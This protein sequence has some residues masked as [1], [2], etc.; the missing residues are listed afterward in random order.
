MLFGGSSR[1]KSSSLALQPF[2]LKL[3]DAFLVG[4]AGDPRESSPCVG[5]IQKWLDDRKVWNEAGSMSDLTVRKDLVVEVMEK[6]DPH[7][8]Y[9]ISKDGTAVRL[10]CVVFPHAKCNC[11]RDRYIPAKKIGEHTNFTF[12]PILQLRSARYGT[13]EGNI[14]MSVAAGHAPIST[15]HVTGTGLSRQKSEA[16]QQA[17]SEWMKRAAFSDK[18]YHAAP[19]DV[20]DVTAFQTATPTRVPLTELLLRGSEVMGTGTSKEQ[21]T[22]EAMFELAKVR[23]LKKYAA[24]MKHPMLVVGTNNWIRQRIPFFLLQQYD[25]HLLFY[26]NAMPAWV[27]G[28]VAMSRA[29]VD[30]QPIFAFGSHAQILTAL[31]RALFRVLEACRPVDWD[32]AEHANTHSQSRIGSAQKSKLNLWWNNWIYRCPKISLREVLTLENYSPTLET[33]RDFFRDGEPQLNLLQLNGDLLPETIRTLVSVSSAAEEPKLFRNVNG[34]G[35]WRSFQDA[36]G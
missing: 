27:V 6:R 10:E 32:E 30:E 1:S 12:S 3:R 31:D 15:K 21:A 28:V 33:W 13:P 11:Q 18:A 16:R 36:L 17:V 26:P 23:T 24:S 9:E 19:S 22:M 34:I 4:V 2:V 29:K 7:R 25:L 14:W 5:C 8:F 20:A 35:T